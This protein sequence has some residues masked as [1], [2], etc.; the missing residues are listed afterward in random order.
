MRGGRIAKHRYSSH[1]CFHFACEVCLDYK[2]DTKVIGV[3]DKAR[4]LD[5]VD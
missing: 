5:F 4:H 2:C 3:A 1:I